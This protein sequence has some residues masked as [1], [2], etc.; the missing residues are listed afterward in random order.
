MFQGLPR[1]EG[2]DFP[3]QLGEEN[4][5][6]GSLELLLVISAT[7]WGNVGHGCHSR[8]IEAK[9]GRKFLMSSV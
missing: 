2:G 3:L 7:S 4:Q 8:E 1:G 5:E 9:D 6:R